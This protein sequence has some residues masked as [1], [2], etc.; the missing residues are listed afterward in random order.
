MCDS[1]GATLEQDPSRRIAAESRK[2]FERS[3]GKYMHRVMTTQLHVMCVAHHDGGAQ[4]VSPSLLTI[5]A[6]SCR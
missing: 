4:Y 1:L 2:K 6:A 3:R 5:P